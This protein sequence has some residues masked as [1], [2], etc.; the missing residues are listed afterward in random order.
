VRVGLIIYG[1]LEIVSGGYLYDRML[2]EHLRQQ[3]DEV[4]II[5]LPWRD[6]GRHLSDNLARALR[7]R[8]RQAPLDVLLQDEL[9]HPSLFWLN[10]W[11]RRQVRYPLVTI[12]HHLRCSEARPAWQNRL[13][14]WVERCY[15]VTLDGFIFNSE[16]TSA[17]VERLIGA[18][19]ATVVAAPGGDRLQPTLTPVQIAARAR[20]PGPLRVLFVGNLIPR[21]ELH[22]LLTA[23][24]R[25]PHEGWQLEVVGSPTVDPAYVQAIRRQIAHTG[26]TRQVTLLGTLSDTDLAARLAQNHLLAVPS[27]YEGFGIVYLEGMGFGLPAVA[28]TAGGAS[29]ILTHGHDG[30]L[31][32]PGDT[33]TLAHYLAELHQHRERLAQLSLAAHERYRT[34]PTWT[35]STARIRQFLQTLVKE[36][37]P[38]P[39]PIPSLAT[40][41]PRRA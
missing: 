10:R 1:S 21:K 30:F 9:N 12:V 38:H 25:L 27:S 14:R 20:H 36:P 16:T 32:T 19:R 22:T 7:R 15:L 24:A 17:A 40:S 8:L 41:L 23:L 34:H 5:A 39:H 37:C 18:Q 33:M 35:T 13:Y 26:L 2:V 28:S 3:G 31:I 29:E 11:L 6:Y 4:D